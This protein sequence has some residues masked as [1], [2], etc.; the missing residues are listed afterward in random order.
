MTE[1]EGLRAYYR[2]K[3]DFH[4]RRANRWRIVMAAL[5]VLAILVVAL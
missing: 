2:Y 3:A 5:A 1:W 4:R